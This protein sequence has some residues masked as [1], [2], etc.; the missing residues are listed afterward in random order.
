MTFF[1]GI[2]KDYYGVYDPGFYC[3]G[4]AMVA[5]GLTQGLG[6]IIHHQRIHKRQ[7]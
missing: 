6:G 7:S 1:T 5:S 4:V 3:G 2:L